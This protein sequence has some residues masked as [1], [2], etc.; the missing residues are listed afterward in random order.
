MTRVEPSNT[1]GNNETPEAV[2]PTGAQHGDHIAAR[3]P[4]S[5]ETPES[6]EGTD[7][8]VESSTP[9]TTSAETPDGADPD[10]KAGSGLDTEDDGGYATAE[11]VIRESDP[12]AQAA[13]ITASQE[14]SSESLAQATLDA[15][16]PA[17]P[18]IVTPNKAPQNLPSNQPR[19]GPRRKPAMPKRPI[20]VVPGSG[21]SA[22]RHPLASLREALFKDPTSSV[23]IPR[24]EDKVDRILAMM[25]VL[26]LAML[27][28]QQATVDVA[29]AMYDIARAYNMPPLRVVTLPTVFAI[30][31]EGTDRRIELGAIEGRDLRL[32]QA[33]AID[34][35]VDRARRGVIEPDDAIL[36][37]QN[38]FDLK[39]RFNPVVQVFGQ[40]LMTL[41]IGLLI[42]PVIT[43]IPSYL[44]LGLIVGVLL[45]IGQRISTLALALPVICAV[46][47][48]VVAAGPLT[49]LTGEVPIRLIAPALVTFLPGLT[50]TIAAL[51]LTRHEVIS[52]ASRL[53][54]GMSQ[55]LL[56]AFGVVIGLAIVGDT[57]TTDEVVIN[58]MGPL[59]PI[60]AIALLALGYV[61][62]RSAPAGSYLWLVLALVI[63]YSAQRLGLLLVPAEYSGFF[64]ALVVVPLSRF[65]ARF[66]TA[67]S[68]MVTQLV[69]F[70]ILVPGALGFISFAQAA[71][72]SG[73]TVNMMVTTG[74]AMFSIAL[75]M[76][77][78]TSLIRDTASLGT[79]LRRRP[80]KS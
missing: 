20:V 60:L 30:Q 24:P 12:E 74:M 72:G 23:R 31:I 1:S 44:G 8:T 63:T 4:D 17:P 2:G 15:E 59:T 50:L 42:N 47:V 70:W 9:D 6:T 73:Q 58:S 28:S 41:A 25:R 13:R 62:S 11:A 27:E 71:A 66:R 40:M 45:L 64:G 29:D 46:V 34:T 35:V 76:I 52:G 80:K 10:R 68:A 26:G 39:P 61:F 5:P 53:I 67:P 69:S 48:T 33:D 56:L 18:R 65:L 51:E 55:L 75:G 78:G 77:V 36:Q 49:G 14:F 54:Y 16:R 57:T 3:S 38:T 79:G 22:L 32:D 19:K 7:H 21:G 37:V 43:A